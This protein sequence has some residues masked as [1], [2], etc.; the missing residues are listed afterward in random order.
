MQVNQVNDLV[1]HA[2]IGN[3]VA[4]EAQ[5]SSSAEFFNVLSNTLY[6]N[7]KL[8]VIRE[9]LCNAWDIHIQEGI[10]DTPVQITLTDNKLTIRDFGTGIHDDHIVDVYLTYGNSTKKLDGTQTGGFGLGSKA[11]WAY[12]DHFEVT[13]F[14]NKIK[15][16]YAM[17]KSSGEVA[18]KP[19]A[20]PIMSVPTEETGLQ[21]SMAIASRTD[22]K[23]FRHIIETIV[24]FGEMNVV[25]NGDPLGTIAFSEAKKG[26]MF[27]P[28]S[29][30]TQISGYQS[31][32]I[33]IRY[34]NVVYPLPQHPELN[35][36]MGKATDLSNRLSGHSGYGGYHYNLILQAKPDTISVTPSRE[37]LSMTDHTVKHAK[38]LIDEFLEYLNSDLESKCISKTKETIANLWTTGKPGDLFCSNNTIPGLFQPHNMYDRKASNIIITNSEQAAT[39]Y[40]SNAYPSF[41]GFAEKDVMM[42]LDALEKSGFGNR[43]KIQSFRR[44]YMAQK[45]QSYDGKKRHPRTNQVVSDWFKRVLVAPLLKK[46]DAHPDVSIEKLMVR[47]QHTEAP[48]ANRYHH[49]TNIRTILASNLSPRPLID[50]MP[51]LRNFIVISFNRIDI[52]ERLHHFP[53][54]KHW[55]GDSSEMFCYI[56]PRTSGKAEAAKAFFEEQGMIVVDLTKAQ[57]WEPE[58]VVYA[59]PK[60]A[61][62][63]PRKKGLPQLSGIIQSG[64][65]RPSLIHESEDFPRIEEPKFIIQMNARAENALNG[66]M[67][68]TGL[69]TKTF[70][71][72]R[73]G[74]QTGVCANHNQYA[75]FKSMGLSFLEDHA[76]QDISEEI[77]KNPRLQSYYKMRYETLDMATKADI[78]IGTRAFIRVIL[79]DQNL[80]KEFGVNHSATPDDLELYEVFKDLVSSYRYTK[81]TFLEAATKHFEGMKADPGFVALVKKLSKSKFLKYMNAS[82]IEETLESMNGQ[83]PLTQLMKKHKEGML[84]LLL[85]AIEG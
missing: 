10:T 44:E 79:G 37:S 66:F 29:R 46:I 83:K 51:F 41:K 8:A 33:F 14:H 35:S 63:K 69:T 38:I 21:V 60:P 20:L 48:R 26:F 49:T 43:G 16:I 81:N 77:I 75:R 54:M 34:G 4:R 28:M 2:V 73:Y 39:A 31:S 85:Y 36:V 32:R 22:V 50:Y 18:G 64:R 56:V 23:E 12:V 25:M 15:T 74:A 57:K 17:S 59:T 3:K 53:I 7:K 71:I 78:P 19:S 42:R 67:S 80:A 30:M 11:P 58:E 82:E 70:I 9:V 6:S 52:E 13:S 45:N 65:P 62:V 1:T 40:L 72:K 76:I 55:L 27:I 24:E 61:V 5:I 84:D 47:G 68:R